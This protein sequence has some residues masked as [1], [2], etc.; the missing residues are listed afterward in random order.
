MRG[1]AAEILGGMRII[2]RIRIRRNKIYGKQGEE[3]L[4]RDERI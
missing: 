4:K 1:A 2:R 3:D